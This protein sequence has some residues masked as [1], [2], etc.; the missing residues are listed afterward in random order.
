MRSM[1]DSFMIIGLI[2][3]SCFGIFFSSET[4]SGSTQTMQEVVRE[5]NEDYQDR[6]ETIKADNSY[7]DL[8][9]S[10]SRAV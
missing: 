8:E 6:L 3:S 7:D 1:L 2:V 10:G 4:D 5:I 9:M